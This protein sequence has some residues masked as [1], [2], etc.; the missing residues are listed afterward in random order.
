MVSRKF[1]EIVSLKV[2]EARKVQFRIH[3]PD[4][5]PDG[6]LGYVAGELL[7][8]LLHHPKQ[9]IIK[10]LQSFGGDREPESAKLKLRIRFFCIS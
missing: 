2:Q 6:G 5:L 7:D 4:G 10:D 1:R 9:T 3:R 8:L